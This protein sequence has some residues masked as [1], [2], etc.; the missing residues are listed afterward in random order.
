MRST[1]YVF[2]ILMAL[3]LGVS[4]TGI[5]QAASDLDYA[6]QPWSFYV[7]GGYSPVVGGLNHTL[8]DGWNFTVGTGYQF[9]K[10]WGLNLEYMNHHL[11]IDHGVLKRYSDLLGGDPT[12]GDAH[13]WSV[14]LNPTWTFEI[15]RVVGGYLV[16]G[17]GY[18]HVKAQITTPGL[19]YMPPYCDYYWGCWPGGITPANFIV[20]ERKDDTGG[21][22]AG[23]GFTFNLRHGVQFYIESRYHYVFIHGPDLQIF[24]FTA[25]FRFS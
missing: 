23:V 17:G 5:A 2:G 8:S 1:S 20:G 19:A 6:T 21:M 14:S 3:F 7:G 13:M 24:P 22:N 10:A 12:D 16:A 4:A 9:T 18:Y 25:G 11:G 15:N